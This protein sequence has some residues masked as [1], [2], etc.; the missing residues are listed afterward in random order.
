MRYLEK[1]MSTEFSTFRAHNIIAFNTENR[2][3]VN[4]VTDH[5]KWIVADVVKQ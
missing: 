3:V 4:V 1:E 2:A 5:L